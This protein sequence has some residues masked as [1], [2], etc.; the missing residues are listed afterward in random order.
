MKQTTLLR[1]AILAGSALVAGF[2]F[3]GDEPAPAAPSSGLDVELGFGYSSEYLFRSINFG[4]DLFHAS[5]GLSGS[6]SL[7]IVGDVDLS[8]GLDLR[9]VSVAAEISPNAN[10]TVSGH[11]MRIGAAATKALGSLDLTVG[12]TNYSY[13]GTADD[14]GGDVM[15]PYIALST[16]LA[17]L[18]VGIAVYDQDWFSTLDNYIEITAGRSVE[19][20]GLGLCVK[21]VIGT[22]NEFDD[23]HYGIC[24][25][26]PIDA[27][28]SI[29]VTPHVSA[30]FGD[31]FSGDDEFSAGVNLGFGF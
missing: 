11:E 8:A 7:P 18:N 5:I 19:L 14:G 21:G 12:V 2:A 24:V 22:W 27:S 29:T 4:D 17:G 28:D 13:F 23:T 26:L 31:T 30:V 15:E 3:A 6:G 9:T 1:S 10:G 16:E 25:G 20:G